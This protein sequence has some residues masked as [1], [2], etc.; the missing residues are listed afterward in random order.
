MLSNILKRI[1]QNAM[2]SAAPDARQAEMNLAEAEDLDFTGLAPDGRRPEERAAAVL[3]DMTLEEKLIFVTGYKSLGIH[4]LPR[5]GLPSVWMTD[6]TSGPRSYG[7]TT[8]FPSAVAMAATWDPALVAEA[9]D[10]I[11]ESTR[12]KGASILLGPG[13]NIARIPTCGRNFEYMGEDPYLAGTLA[14]A[15]VKACTE[16]GVICTVKHMA[17]N[18]SEYDRHKISSDLD[19]RTLREIYLPAF[20]ATVKTGKTPGL[21]SAYNPVNGVWASENRKLLTVILREEWE[22]DGIVVSDWDSLYSTSGPLKSGLD[23]EMPRARWLTPERVKAAFVTGDAREADLDRMAGNLLRTLFSAGV[24]DRPVKDPEAREFHPDHE[25][26][27]LKAARAGIVLLKNENS[28]L[29]LPRGPGITIAV[30]GPLAV[31]SAVL[32][33]GSC[34]IARTTGTINLLEG[35]KKVA[36]SAAGTA[37]GTKIVHVSSGN[38]GR[39]SQTI[40]DADAVIITCGFNYMNESELYDR[41]W[42]LPRSQRK[43]IHRISRLNSRCIVT[44]SAGGG[45]ETE[46]WVENVPALIHGMYL[47]QTV[48]TATAEILFGI[49]NPSGKLPFTMAR[50]WNDIPAVRGYPRRYWTTSPGRIAAGQG[51]PRFRKVRHWR[52]SEGL[53]VGYRHFDTADIEPAFPFGHGLSYTSF[54]IENMQLSADTIGPEDSLDVTVRVKNTG[55]RFGSEVVQIYVADIESRLPRPVKELKGFTKLKLEPGESVEAVIHLDKRAFRYWDPGAGES[56]GSGGWTAEPGEFRILAGRGSRNI[57]AEAIVTLGS[58][59][60]TS[61]PGG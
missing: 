59:E 47:G 56:G 37:E 52:Y 16:R 7:A 43:L 2:L 34:H 13:V 51:N 20:E 18:N 5:H 28:A 49:V 27:A 45:V 17:A 9:A 25:A 35:L 24:Y 36:G 1:V 41:P 60:F 29:P 31:D 19:E 4:P 21:M 12:A 58:P 10:H 55:K 3:T 26:A 32:G 61:Q 6:A 57:E 23:I 46:S 39:D 48:G 8:A 30:C 54:F 42:R 53:M 44:I 33:G 50:K 14:S 38:L 22:F 11:A 15:Y 40:E